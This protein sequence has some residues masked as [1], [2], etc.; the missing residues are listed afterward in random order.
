MLFHY[1]PDVEQ[2]S[3]LKRLI[4]ADAQKAEDVIIVSELNSA[5]GQRPSFLG[6]LE[7]ARAAGKDGTS[8]QVHDE[9]RTGC[10]YYSKLLD[11]VIVVF[12][13]NGNK[14]ERCWKYGTEVGRDS[15]HPAVCPRCAQVLKSG[16]SA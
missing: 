11:S 5:N 7:Q 12:G 8:A 1:G 15:S 2:K 6:E 3:A 4:D 13:A 14:C 9:S 10:A 16:A